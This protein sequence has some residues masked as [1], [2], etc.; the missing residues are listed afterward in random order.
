[1][2]NA[3]LILGIV[4]LMVAGI[5]GFLV[6][7]ALIRGDEPEVLGRLDLPAVG[8][9]RP[10]YLSDGTPVWVARHDDGTVD[11]LSGFDTHRP[12]NMG[13]VLW[14]C[15]EARGLENPEHGSLYDEYGLRLGGPAP[16]G[17]PPYETIIEGAEVV[18]GALGPAPP[19]DTPH[20]G[21][22][23][24]E[25]DWCRD[26]DDVVVYHTFEDWQAWDSPTAAVAAAPSGWIL[27]EG[28]LALRN[29]AVV[30]CGAR[31]CADSAVAANVDPTDAGREFGPL[32]GDRF[33]AQVRDGVLA[34]VTRVRPADSIESKAEP[35]AEP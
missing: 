13:K 31:G 22:D 29:G 16:T 10:D 24:S 15:E 33:I 34:G 27:L 28:T 32:F 4:V 1:M 2:A 14:W 11:V 3:R 5:G 23:A 35:P 7:T 12:S 25:R 18:V 9:V 19:Y 21:P 8:E 20:P 26:P 30:I 17:L 6:I